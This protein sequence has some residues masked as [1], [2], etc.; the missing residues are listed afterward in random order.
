MMIGR[1]FS[2]K[3]VHRASAG[4]ALAILLT[5]PLSAA[6]PRFFKTI[7][8]RVNRIRPMPPTCNRFRF[9]CRGI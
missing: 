8:L 3:C 5:L 6:G 9:T 4:I 1:L 7:R 2:L